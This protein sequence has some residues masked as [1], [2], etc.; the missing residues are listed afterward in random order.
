MK[1]NKTR[2]DYLF[3]NHLLL[4]IKSYSQVWLYIYL[5]P[6]S[7]R[8]RHKNLDEFQAALVY[9]AKTRITKVTE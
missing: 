8:Q 7:W 5:I 9:I 3:K 1:L 4:E 6:A 2:A